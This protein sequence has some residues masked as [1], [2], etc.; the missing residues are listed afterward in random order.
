ML[1]LLQLHAEEPTGI[2]DTIVSPPQVSVLLSLPQL[3]MPKYPV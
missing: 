2:A 3:R 1:G